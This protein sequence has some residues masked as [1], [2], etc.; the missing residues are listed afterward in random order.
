MKTTITVTSRGVVTLPLGL[1]KA[2]GIKA[3]DTLIAE[4]TADGLL[5]RPAVTLPVEIYT[6]RQVREF[7]KSEAELAQAMHRPAPA[8]ESARRKRR[9]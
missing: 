3:D 5:L 1:R 2:L 8:R 6:D 7:D 9:A 4:T